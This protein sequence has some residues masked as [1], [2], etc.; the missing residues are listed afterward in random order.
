MAKKLGKIADCSPGIVSECKSHNC[1]SSLCSEDMTQTKAFYPPQ[2]G[3]TDN[4]IR[5]ISKLRI[6]FL[7]CGMAVGQIPC[8]NCPNLGRHVFTSVQLRKAI[9]NINKM[10]SGSICVILV[11]HII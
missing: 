3:E 5:D 10:I 9:T 1:G 6:L 8:N 7:H 4:S 2:K 11:I